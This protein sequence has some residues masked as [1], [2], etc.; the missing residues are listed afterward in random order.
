MAAF[1]LSPM[2][3]LMECCLSFHIQIVLDN[4]K[5]A[6][7]DPWYFIKVFTWDLVGCAYIMLCLNLML[8]PLYL[9]LFLKLFLMAA[10]AGSPYS[11]AAM[12]QHAA[13]PSTC[14]ILLFVDGA[15]RPQYPCMTALATGHSKHNNG[16][17]VCTHS[18]WLCLALACC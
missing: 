13:V 6:D 4:T 16:V 9:L 11:G 2:L 8:L 3:I 14:V 15:H 18:G 10:A 7:D 1:M 12:I 17:L 5:Q